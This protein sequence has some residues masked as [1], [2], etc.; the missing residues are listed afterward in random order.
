[1]ENT[2]E[3]RMDQFFKQ[4]EMRTVELV[5]KAPTQKEL[6]AAVMSGFF[7]GI[8]SREAISAEKTA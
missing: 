5:Q 2:T 7:A 8:Q 1:M 6:A 4:E 3:K